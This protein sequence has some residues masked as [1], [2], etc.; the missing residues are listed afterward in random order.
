MSDC[1]LGPPALRTV[2]SFSVPPLADE[3]PSP[4]GAGRMTSRNNQHVTGHR[5]GLQI[6]GA[7]IGER[8]RAE[9]L[10]LHR[11]AERH[12]LLKVSPE[13]Q[14]LSGAVQ[15]G[16]AGTARAKPAFRCW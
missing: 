4:V 6:D 1:E 8:R 15:R 13:R 12:A 7:R 11:P 5:V 9:N 14:I 10:A 3:D 2:L 16:S